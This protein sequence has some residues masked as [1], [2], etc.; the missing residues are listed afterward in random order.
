MIVTFN[1]MDKEKKKVFGFT[2]VDSIIVEGDVLT[3]K[4]R[5]DNKLCTEEYNTPDFIGVSKED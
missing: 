5:K 3:I 2:K 4:Y 1:V